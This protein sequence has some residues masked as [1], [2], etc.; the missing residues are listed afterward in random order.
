MR[1]FVYEYLCGGERTGPGA[2]SLR[3]EGWAMLAAVLED[4][5]RCPGVQVVTLVN[6][7]LLRVVARGRPPTSFTASAARPGEE[8]PAFRTLARTAD[9]SLIIAPEFDG[10][11][12]ER[13]RWVEEEGGRLLGPSAAAVRLTGD[14]LLLARH[15]DGR[16]IP[17][18]P[19]LP[20]PSAAPP[21]PF[22]L[23]CKPRDGAGSQATFLARDPEG[24]GQAVP[25]ARAEGW[26]GEM[27]LQPHV[28]G[29]AV[30]V[31]LLLGPERRLALPAA[32]QTLSADGR[33]RYQGGSLPL[34][35]ELDRR[36]RQ[37]AERAVQAV[38]GLRGYVG[39]D[40][41]LGEAA[42][43]SG[44]RVIEINPRLTTS[45]VG[46][47]RLA[48]FNLAEALL[49]VVTATTLPE[50]KWRPGPVRFRS[51]GGIEPGSGGRQSA[52]S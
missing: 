21:L 36:A 22:P 27:V 31:A 48:R 4:F 42:D 46:L 35:E 45:Y 30:S 8:E 17:T 18:P 16:G 3:A 32:G 20:F 41:V 15:L 13:C 24:L 6:S 33:F 23:V 25:R 52:C 14:K 26:P 34:A 28:P 50:M 44:D 19:T 5:S 9:F 47:R 29:R 1:V 49:A 37:L 51:D 39:V 43:G 38:E 12:A 10:L 2:A 11:L 7:S 40:L